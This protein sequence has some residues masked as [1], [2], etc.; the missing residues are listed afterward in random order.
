ADAC[1]LETLSRGRSRRKQAALHSPRFFELSRHSRV[2]ESFALKHPRVRD[3]RG[4]VAGKC[5]EE[6]DPFRRKRVHLS[7]LDVE[8]ADQLAAHLERNIDLRTRILLTRYVERDVPHIRRVEGLAA[9]GCM[10][11][12]TGLSDL[13]ASAFQAQFSGPACGN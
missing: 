2:F 8:N 3:R 13:E 1:K 11:S 4:D 10:S 7:V 6:A 9:R 5:L 12:D